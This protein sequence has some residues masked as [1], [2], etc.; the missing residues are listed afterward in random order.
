MTGFHKSVRDWLLA[1]RYDHEYTVSVS[2]GKRRL[3]LLCEQV[4]EKIKSDVSSGVNLELTNEVKHALDYGHEY[5]LESNVTD[6]IFWLVDMVIMYVQ[7]SV[8]QKRTLDL[9]NVLKKI[10]QSNVGLSPE[11][12]QRI[13]WHLFELSIL[14]KSGQKH[15]YLKNVLECSQEDLFTDDKRK[16]ARALYQGESKFNFL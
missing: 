9:Q 7:I 11:L 16:I 1:N 2:G 8:H 10:F 13:Y 6:S 15:F 4:F 5:L 14:E 12:E 3:W